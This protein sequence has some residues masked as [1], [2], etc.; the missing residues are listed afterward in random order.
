MARL[1]DSIAAAL[2]HCP[3]DR[4]EQREMLE[5]YVAAFRG[6]RSLV[7]YRADDVCVPVCVCV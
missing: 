7:L 1:A 2:P 6:G 5:H 4:P 3:P